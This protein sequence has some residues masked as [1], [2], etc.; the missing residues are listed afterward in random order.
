L[1][2]FRDYH[3]RSHTGTSTGTIPCHLLV[4]YRAVTCVESCRSTSRTCTVCSV[5]QH[6]LSLS[7]L[8]AR[9]AVYRYCK[10]SMARSI[11][12]DVLVPVVSC[13]SNKAVKSVSYHRFIPVPHRYG[14]GEALKTLEYGFYTY[15][16]YFRFF[17]IKGHSKGSQSQKIFRKA[18]SLT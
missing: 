7:L 12:L 4:P 11:L 6:P 17:M 8:I 5:R 13:R 15:C 9:A 3:T 16:M 1:L 2:I 18:R 14:T 10:D